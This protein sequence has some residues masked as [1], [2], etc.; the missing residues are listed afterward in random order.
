MISKVDCLDKGYVRL[1]TWMPWNMVGLYEALKAGEFARAQAMLDEDDLAGV[2]AA[3][4]SWAKES[5]HLTD[6]DRRLIAFLG[7]RHEDSPFR[8]TALTFEV[9]APLMLARQWFK[10][11]IGSLHTPDSS[12]FLG[13]EFGQG[14]D[15]GFGDLFYA[16]NE[17]S[18]R[19]ITS[20][21]EFYIP[22]VWR[23]KPEHGKQG[24]GPRLPAWQ[25]AISSELLA[26]H[27]FKSIARYEEA[28]NDGVSPEMARL[29]LP[30][31][32]LYIHW[33]WTASLPAV[34][35]FLNQRLADG[36]QTEI[37]EYAEAVLKLVN[38]MGVYPLSTA[39]LLEEKG[40]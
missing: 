10:Y 7:E 23:S 37:R 27:L 35:H 3:R 4:A 2:N 11:R 26:R 16:R 30:A 29:F 13:I 22:K 1:I 19:Y 40:Q 32:A 8:H 12:E 38:Q 6:R 36:A 15:G 18:R 24:S 39:A 21:P 34:C 9:K 5:Q 14:D 28:L 31:Y 25:G 17:S 20:K 33:R